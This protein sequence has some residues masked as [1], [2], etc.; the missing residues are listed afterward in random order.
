MALARAVL[1][2]PGVL[3]LDEVGA[4]LDDASL[5]VLRAALAGFLD[6]RTVIEAAHDRPL[7]AD[8]PRLELVTTAVGA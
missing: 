7:L 6:A 8:A 3:L 2:D 4:H 1:R 5:V